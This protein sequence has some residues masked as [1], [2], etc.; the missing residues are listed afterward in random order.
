MDNQVSSVNNFEVKQERNESPEG[1]NNFQDKLSRIRNL[2][3]II[4]ESFQYQ[5]V[6]LEEYLSRLLEEQN[7]EYSPGLGEEEKISM[8]KA[9]A[10]EYFKNYANEVFRNLKETVE[11]E[12][13]HHILPQSYVNGF[14]NDLKR[15]LETNLQMMSEEIIDGIVR[16]DNSSLSEDSSIQDGSKKIQKSKK[17]KT[18]IPKKALI[19]L[20]NWLTDHF[21]DPYPSH[22]E[23]LA[24]AKEAGI[25]F[26]QVQNWFTNARGRVWKKS[27]NP[28]KFSSQIQD[29]LV[30]KVAKPVHVEEK[31]E[32]KNTMNYMQPITYTTMSYPLVKPMQQI[33]Q[34]MMQQMMQPTYILA[35]QFR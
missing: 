21:Q 14:I 6:D 18:K 32:I 4:E 12:Q 20:K 16:Q 35:P 9:K 33:M 19:I 2:A 23:K 29:V 3:N 31:K 8:A 28:E 25:S 15:N 26:K 11:K 34:P 5:F 22:I 10:K 30:E 13:L 27:Y 17:G 24:L 1:P 7:Y